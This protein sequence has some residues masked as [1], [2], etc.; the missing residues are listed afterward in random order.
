V[1]EDG[2][3]GIKDKADGRWLQTSSDEFG[4]PAGVIII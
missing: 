4:H 2:F 3:T 1:G